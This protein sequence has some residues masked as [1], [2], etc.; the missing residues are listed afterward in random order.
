[1]ICRRDDLSVSHA[2]CYGFGNWN[3]NQLDLTLCA[4][5]CM[6][7]FTAIWLELVVS[8]VVDNGFMRYYRRQKYAYHVYNATTT[9]LQTNSIGIIARLWVQPCARVSTLKHSGNGAKFSRLAVSIT[10]VLCRNCKATAIVRHTIT[11]HADIST[12]YALDWN[13]SE[14]LWSKPTYNGMDQLPK[15]TCTFFGSNQFGAPFSPLT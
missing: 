10:S 8:Y 3:A 15:H 13:I 4:R 2:I 12:V 1:M 11:T 5:V 14:W 9:L 7:V 6:I